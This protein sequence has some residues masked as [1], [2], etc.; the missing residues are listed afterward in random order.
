MKRTIFIL[1]VIAAVLGGCKK[2]DW[3]DWKAQNELWLEQNKIN[4]ANDPLFHVSPT[5]LQYRI[6]YAGNP[7]D[8]KPSAIS[9]VWCTYSGTFINGAKFDGGTSSFPVSNLVP[10]FAEGLK[11]IH[12]PGIIELFIP[13]ELGYGE[14]GSGTEGTA[15]YIPPFSTLIFRVELKAIQ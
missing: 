4:H 9:T 3:L 8:A 7:T 10:G 2:N 5:G 11:Y 15:S 1:V 12:N 6:I 13:S 14:K